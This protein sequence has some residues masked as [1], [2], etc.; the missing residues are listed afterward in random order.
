[1]LL[2]HHMS[3]EGQWQRALHDQDAARALVTGDARLSCAWDPPWLAQKSWSYWGSPCTSPGNV[4]YRIQ[5][6]CKTRELTPELLAQAEAL[7]QYVA[8]FAAGYT[9][10]PHNR[11][12]HSKNHAVPGFVYWPNERVLRQN[13]AP[14]DSRMPPLHV[15]AGV[16]AASFKGASRT[17]WALRPC[18]G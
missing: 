8:A 6:A 14:P 13:D 18:P 17:T 16:P 5:S 11:R 15:P 1:M 7:D 9:S 10:D 4:L 2:N 3:F 12:G